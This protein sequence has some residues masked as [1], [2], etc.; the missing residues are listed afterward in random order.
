MTKKLTTEEWIDKANKR[1]NNFYDYSKSVYTKSTEKIEII[2][3]V[4]GSFWQLAKNHI[5]L[6]ATCPAC[7]GVK[8]LTTEEWIELAKKVHNDVYDYSEVVYK[9]AITP[10]IIKCKQHG[11]FTQ[12][13]RDHRDGHGCNKC[14]IIARTKLGR[15]IPK[16]NTQA[17][18]KA[19]NIKHNNFYD[20]T[21]T[22]YINSREFVSV[23]C[24][25]HGIFKLRASSHLSGVGCIKCM[26]KKS[27][28]EKD[29][30]NFIKSFDV[31]I[32]ES[33]RLLI[34]PYEL[35][36]Y[37]PDHNLAIEFCGNYWHTE[38]YGKDRH[39]HKNK[40]EMCKKQGVQLITIF[41]DEW[42]DRNIQVKSKLKS[43]LKIDDRDKIYARLCKIKPINNK[44]RKT[45]LNKNHI[46]GDGQGKFSYGLYYEDE[47]IAC[48]T[49]KHIKNNDYYLNRYATSK[50]IPGGSSRLLKHFQRNHEWNQIIS[51]ADLRWSDGNLYKKTG[52]DLESELRPDYF[53]FYGGERKHKFNFRRKA[54]AVMLGEA[55]NPDE[56]EQENCSRNNIYRIWDC[57]K[58]RFVINNN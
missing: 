50:Q 21:L 24:P 58:L 35:D 30:V 34:S 44:I 41:E 14:S 2:C 4:H 47:L 7:A 17:F 12:I 40:Y 28:K 6:T 55:F 9:N 56:S 11:R 53:Y 32:I 27:K 1:H 42:D 13:P 43:L 46:Q 31:S 33:D 37:I 26:N 25:N 19:S 18:V 16:S 20:Y 52:W 48:M 54:L 15:G 8:K 3:P 36:V 29:L 39:Y 5:N 23:T 51:F 10:V 38:Q 49:F 22:E 57:G 45:F